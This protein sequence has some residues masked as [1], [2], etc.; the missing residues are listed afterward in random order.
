MLPAGRKT[1]G[2]DTEV[3]VFAP[4]GRQIQR[5]R[6]GPAH[7]LHVLFGGQH[8]QPFADDRM[9]TEPPVF[10]KVSAKWVIVYIRP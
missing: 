5:R 3:A 7:E 8:V 1:H 10:S 6:R 4:L 9:P 2:L